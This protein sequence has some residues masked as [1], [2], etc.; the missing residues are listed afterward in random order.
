MKKDKEMINYLISKIR[1]IDAHVSMS[2]K[3][4]FFSGGKQGYK[5]VF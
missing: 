1:D 4:N 3:K 5:D 2:R